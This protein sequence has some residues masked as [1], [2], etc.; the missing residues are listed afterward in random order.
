M[1]QD[2]LRAYFVKLSKYH[3]LLNSKKKN[4]RSIKI[5]FDNKYVIINML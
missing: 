1:L 3:L 4:N 5:K 2:T